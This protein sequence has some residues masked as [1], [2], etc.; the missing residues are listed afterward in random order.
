MTSSKM[1]KYLY[2]N[3]IRLSSSI[4][5]LYIFCVYMNNKETV[6]KM[7]TIFL[8]HYY[9]LVNNFTERSRKDQLVTQQCISPE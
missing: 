2:M 3:R 9:G 1:H 5:N 6:F 8:F 4:C 7:N